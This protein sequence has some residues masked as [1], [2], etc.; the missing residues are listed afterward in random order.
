YFKQAQYGM[1]GRMALILLLLQ[2]E[3]FVL[4]ERDT[5]VS[6]HHCKNARCITQSEDYLPRRSYEKL[7]MQMCDFCDK[8]MD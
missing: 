7:G 3:D 8:R 1:F 5:F 6:E 4:N 2:D